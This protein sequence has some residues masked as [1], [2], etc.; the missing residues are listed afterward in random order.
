MFCSISVLFLFSFNKVWQYKVILMLVSK[1]VA[2]FLLSTPAAVGT[3]EWVTWHARIMKTA[4]SVFPLE[5]SLTCDQNKIKTCKAR[6]M[7]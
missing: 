2:Y 5:R 1:C 4:A 3:N 6:K 7:V